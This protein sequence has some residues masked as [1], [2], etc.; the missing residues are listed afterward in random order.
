MEEESLRVGEEEREKEIVRFKASGVG[1]L[2]S[3]SY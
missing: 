3:S 2:D 1:I